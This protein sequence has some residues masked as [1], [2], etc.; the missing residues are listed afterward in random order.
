MIAGARLRAATKALL[1]EDPR[2]TALL[3]RMASP[4]IE[5]AAAEHDDGAA[6]R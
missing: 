1:L 2:V 6:A 3:D 5:T 4:D